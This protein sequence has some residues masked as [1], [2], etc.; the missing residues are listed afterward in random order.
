M[1]YFVAVYHLT[2]LYY[3]KQTAFEQF[4]LVDGGIFPQLFWGGWL[5]VGTIVPLALLFLPGLKNMRGAVT[6]ASLL[7][8]APLLRVASLRPGALDPEPATVTLAPAPATVS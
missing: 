5:L 3:A 4:I 6:L 7:P 2:N 1:F 8:G